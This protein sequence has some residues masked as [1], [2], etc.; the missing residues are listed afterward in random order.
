[1]KHDLFLSQNLEKYMDQINPLASREKQI[2]KGKKMHI[3]TERNESE[4]F[5]KK[6]VGGWGSTLTEAGGWGMGEGVCGGETQEG[7]NVCNVNK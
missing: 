4:W 3:Q 6:R 5:K 7:D 2:V 1:M